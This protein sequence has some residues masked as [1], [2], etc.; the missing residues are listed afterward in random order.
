MD[1]TTRTA[2]PLPGPWSRL[3]ARLFHP[4][5]F[6]AVLILATL[7]ARHD[8]LS[9]PISQVRPTLTAMITR[10]LG[11]DLDE[12]GVRAL[13]YPR[14]DFA[15]DQPGYLLQEFPVMNLAGVVLEKTLGLQPETAYRLPSLVCFA[16]MLVLLFA[17][18]RAR[19]GT[20]EA[21]AATLLVSSFPIA[22]EHSVEVMPE[23][24]VLTAFLAGLY[25]FDRH[26]AGGRSRHLVASALCFGLML[27]TKP[28]SGLLL[29][30]PL[31]LFLGQRGTL[32]GLF[33][34]YALVGVASA[35]PLAA[36]LVHVWRVNHASVMDDGRT[37][38]VLAIDNYLGQHDRWTLLATAETYTRFVNQL[39]DAYGSWPL[40]LFASG[41]AY[42]LARRGTRALLGCWLAALLLYFL[43]LP[44]NTTTHA[45][46]THPFAPLIAVG[47]A[48]AIGWL[49]RSG[50]RL[51]PR[52]GQQSVQVLLTVAALVWALQA[53][54]KYVPPVDRAKR[55]FGEAMQRALSPRALGIIASD[56]KG[57]WNGELF[58]VS[59]TRGWRASVRVG[60]SWR[61][62]SA[63]FI[64][65]KLQHGAEFLAHY[66]PPAELA[67]RLPDLYQRLSAR[68]AVLASSPDWIVF[69]LRE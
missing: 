12:I 22:V 63:E 23:Q 57:V 44:F 38:A 42:G 17:F 34:R 62:I 51:V 30:V 3:R 43:V 65:D 37:A 52:A 64:A 4:L 41:S 5:V 61:P 45:Y 31:G 66:G 28:T 20:A 2:G 58:Y 67:A 11:R 15:G 13:F 10:N 33:P 26:L 6:P 29:F 69:S 19:S 68:N 24:G 18:V 8:V 27:L 36:W 55:A 39:A 32:R 47:A 56:E 9:T 48:L 1:S 21:I 25:L 50:T 7:V 60:P 49:V 40:L 53:H 16:G 46:Y 54:W 59:D 14:V 35:L